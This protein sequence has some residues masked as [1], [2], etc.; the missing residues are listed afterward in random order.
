MT[1]AVGLS[2]NL[3]AQPFVPADRPLAAA[4]PNRYTAEGRR[5]V[6]IQVDD[7]GRAEVTALLEEHLRNMHE[8]SPPERSCP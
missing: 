5:R 1:R 6:Q 2:T 7:P 3:L 8:P 4:E